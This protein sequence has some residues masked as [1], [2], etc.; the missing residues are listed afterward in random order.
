MV[1]AGLEPAT[2]GFQVQRPNHLATLPPHLHLSMCIFS[3]FNG[4]LKEL[5]QSKNDILIVQW[6][7]HGADSWSVWSQYLIRVSRRFHKC[8]IKLKRGP[9]GQF[10]YIHVVRDYYITNTF[11]ICDN[12]CS[13]FFKRVQLQLWLLSQT[14]RL[15]QVNNVLLPILHVR[16]ICSQF[17]LNFDTR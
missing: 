4:H 15:W 10:S 1:R 8:P 14:T 3:A 17:E 6:C 9:K 13:H 16:T 12:C 11:I 7:R 2:S 5:F